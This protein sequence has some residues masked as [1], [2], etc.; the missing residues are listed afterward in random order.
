M[1]TSKKYTGVVIHPIKNGKDKS[2][3]IVFRDAAGIPRKLKIGNKSQGITEVYC[4]QKRAEII[5]KIRLGENINLL[6]NKKSKV[7]FG[8]VAVEYFE[9][10]ESNG[11]KSFKNEKNRYKNHLTELGSKNIKNLTDKD[12]ADIKKEK[13][14]SGLAP[15][16][17]NNILGLISAILN[18]AVNF[19]NINIINPI[20][21][22][23]VQKFKIDNSRDRYLDQHEIEILLDAVKDNPRLYLFVRLALSTGG[24][25]NTILN[26]QKKDVDIKNRIITLKDFKSNS[27]YS[28]FLSEKLFNDFSFL[29]N[30][31]PNDYLIGSCKIALNNSTIAKPLRDILNMLFNEGLDKNDRKARVVV[32]SLRHSFASILAIA[33]TSIYII[34]KLLNHSCI[35]MTQRYAKLDKTAGFKAVNSVL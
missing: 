13:L 8:D 21:T 25:F 15:K 18:Y 26:I 19:K 27:T 1:I 7:T 20:T 23:K 30:L 3:Y 33:G 32:H 10:L 16:T 34:Q 22:G 2:L 24:R 31:E 17:C 11:K 29:N 6:D 14:E 35:S 12:I 28:G 9:Y 4:S 5:N